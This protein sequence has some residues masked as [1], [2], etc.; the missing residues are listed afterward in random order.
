MKSVSILLQPFCLYYLKNSLKNDVIWQVTS[1]LNFNLLFQ[2][3]YY[4]IY[5]ASPAADSFT[6]HNFIRIIGNITMIETLLYD[7]I[8]I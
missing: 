7:Q 3:F 8:I 1:V 4:N 2:N 5:S 6:L